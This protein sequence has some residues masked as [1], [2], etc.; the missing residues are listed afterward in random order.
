MRIKEEI[1]RVG[2][3]WL[4]SKSEQKIP[5]ILTISDGG[6][7]ELELFGLLTNKFGS[8]D[9]TLNRINGEIEKH[10]LVTLD[11]CF[12]KHRTFSSRGTSKSLIYAD[13]ALF[14]AA[15]ESEEVFSFNT[16]R[17]SVEGIDEWLNI[18]GIS[19]DNEEAGVRISYSKPDNIL[20]DLGDGIQLN[21]GF[22]SS[23][24]IMAP[25]KEA[26][27]TQKALLSLVSEQELPLDS[28]RTMA[29]RITTFL[30]FAIDKIVSMENIIASSNSLREEIDENETRPIPLQLY[31]RSLP[32]MDN[33]SKIN[34]YNMLFGFHQIQNDLG[35]I[36]KNWLNAYETISPTM[37]LYF[38]VKNGA[39]E[40]ISGQFLALIQGVETYHRRTSQE[41]LLDDSI[42]EELRDTIISLCPDQHKDWLKGRLHHGNEISLRKRIK[43]LIEPF[44]DFFGSKEEQNNFINDLLNTRNYLTHYDPSLEDKA[45]RGQDLLRLHYKL[46]VI[47]QLNFLR[48]LNF[49]DDEVK[50]IFN[51]RLRRKFQGR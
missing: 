39:Y 33:V 51:S 11:N 14:G 4:P 41:K 46:E 22:Q 34:E 23:Y 20:V 26:K 12:Y 8:D 28:F 21:I 18:R 27:I 37:A 31:Y 29:H 5:G 16:F 50:S 30:C 6:S 3:F 43:R 9:V 17:F 48:M 32:H 49:T 42:F 36:L 45:V 10:G 2:Y 13:L 1:K 15:Y 7:I 40:Y 19:V 47:L 38:S 24:P 25:L 35:H 44:A